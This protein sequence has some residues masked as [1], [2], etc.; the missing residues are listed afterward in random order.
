MSL[1]Y[2]QSFLT[3]NNCNTLS[4]SFD[5]LTKNFEQFRINFLSIL[6]VF[7][8]NKNCIQCI[9]TIWSNLNYTLKSSIKIKAIQACP[10]K[11]L[12]TLNNKTNLPTTRKK[13][14]NKAISYLVIYLCVTRRDKS[15]RDKSLSRWGKQYVLKLY[16][17]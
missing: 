16:Q 14:N 6:Y 7:L 11:R 12:S 5:S 9:D 2:K 8:T 3:D 10:Q 1:I 4:N 13:L 15:L 17:T